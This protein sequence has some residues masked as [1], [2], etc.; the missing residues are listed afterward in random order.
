MN[1]F[2]FRILTA[3]CFVFTPFIYFGQQDVKEG[4]KGSIRVILEE[5]FEG[6]MIDSVIVKTGKNHQ[7]S[8]IQDNKMEFDQNMNLIS[9]S[10][11]DDDKAH[12]RTESFFFNNNKL[13][14]KNI[15]AFTF[16]YNYN[17][18]GQISE[19]L[20]LS[21]TDSTEIKLK[22]R[23]SHDEN[24]RL[25]NIWEFDM[26]GGHVRH[27]KN[28]YDEKGRLSK[29]TIRYKDGVEYK[30]Y[31]YNDLGLIEKIEW[32]DFQKGLLER[33]TYSYFANRLFR[34]FH[35]TFDDGKLESTVEYKYDKYEN[36]I[37]VLE[38][39]NSRK[40]HDYEVNVYEYDIA[41]NWVKKTTT[42]ND[43]IFF[44]VERRIKYYI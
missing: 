19:E 34:K 22:Q 15:Q 40:I 3:V 29:E 4:L 38:I 27:Q 25:V 33:T 8:W 9:R 2:T 31:E 28:S 30:V 41:N 35:E 17:T 24:G 21:K 44:I 42:I 39:N 11:Y 6:E 16:I 37:S 18:I 32:F 5:S 36:P 10:F 23:F 1:T 14:K 12:L 13:I 43:A 7:F 26:M 20:I